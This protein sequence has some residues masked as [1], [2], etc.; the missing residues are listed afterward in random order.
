MRISVPATSPQSLWP[1]LWEC[2][3][4]TKGFRMRGLLAAPSQGTCGHC[5]DIDSL[6]DPPEP[7]P[8]PVCM[9][10]GGWR[11]QIPHHRVDPVG[12]LFL[13]G[14]PAPPLPSLIAP[15][16]REWSVP[17]CVAFSALRGRSFLTWTCLCSFDILS[18]HL[19]LNREQG[20]A[21]GDGEAIK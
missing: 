1:G 19:L 21:G 12:V 2:A 14:Y 4:F 18:C 15:G 13:A 20:R 6:G 7:L 9:G 11:R 5:G 17:F 3:Q 8:H 16:A 10:S